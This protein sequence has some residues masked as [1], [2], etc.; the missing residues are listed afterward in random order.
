MESFYE[1][2]LTDYNSLTDNVNFMAVNSKI[3][4]KC[5]GKAIEI[6]FN[7]IIPISHKDFEVNNSLMKEEEFTEMFNL[8][9]IVYRYHSKMVS[10]L[11]YGVSWQF[12][13]F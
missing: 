1:L 3:S 4:Y 9:N 5:W 12:L 7:I 10:K 11:N 2:P 6:D 13:N 8:C